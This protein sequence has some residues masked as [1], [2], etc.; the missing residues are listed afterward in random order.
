MTAQGYVRLIAGRHPEAVSWWFVRTF[1]DGFVYARGG[2][3][4]TARQ[5]RAILQGL[6]TAAGA[7]HRAWIERASHRLRRDGS[8]ELI[9]YG[10]PYAPRWPGAPA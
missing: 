9:D 1:D 4:R 7:E 2:R 10:C 6:W 5:A 8:L 3:C